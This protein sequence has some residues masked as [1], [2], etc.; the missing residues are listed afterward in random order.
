MLSMSDNIKDD[1]KDVVLC[2][3][4]DVIVKDNNVVPYVIKYDQNL[5]KIRLFQNL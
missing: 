1:V 3:I 2:Y 4:R 5:L